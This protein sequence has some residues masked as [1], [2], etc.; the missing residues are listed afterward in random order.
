MG[1]PPVGK[2]LANFLTVFIDKFATSYW[3][4]YQYHWFYIFNSENK[5]KNSV[6]KGLPPVREP[7]AIFLTVFDLKLCHFKLTFGK[8]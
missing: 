1:S 2:P 8:F 7:L 4:I 6:T 5:S 3:V